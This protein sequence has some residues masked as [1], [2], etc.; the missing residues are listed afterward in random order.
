MSQTPSQAGNQQEARNYELRL[1]GHL[2]ARWAS[3]LEAE[4]LVN[5]LDGTSTV[6]AVADQ[7]ALHGLLHKVRD[8]GLPLISVTPSQPECAN[9]APT[10][11]Q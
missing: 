1:Q 5:E 9:H 6:L 11:P 3:H 8:L 2:D 10:G 7:A 4:S